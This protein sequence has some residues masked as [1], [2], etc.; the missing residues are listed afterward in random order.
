MTKSNKTPL[1]VAAVALGTALLLLMLM[2]TNAATLV[3]F[4]LVGHFWYVCVLLLGLAA[5]VSLFQLFK[6]YARYS[7]KAFGGKLELGGPG[8]LMLIIVGLGFYWVP[9][10]TTAFNFTVLVEHQTSGLPFVEAENAMVQ[11]DLGAD[12][13]QELIGAK[14]E[15]HFVN[16]PANFLHQSVQINLLQAPDHQLPEAVQTVLLTGEVINLPVQTKQVTLRGEVVDI[17]GEPV[18]K[19]RIQVQ[20]QVVFSDEAGYF[21]VLLPANLPVAKRHITVV[22]P[23]FSRWRGSFVLGGNGLVVQLQVKS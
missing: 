16:I 4:G 15:V 13:R 2:L 21:A 12:R 8:V 11:I 23:G 18:A 6:S 19:A 22:K 17:K 7:G 10:A 3:E 9:Q 14:G 5:P 1:I 20:E